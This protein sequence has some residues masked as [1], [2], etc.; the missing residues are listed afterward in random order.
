MIY[1]ICIDENYN[2]EG[3]NISPSEIWKA[4]KDLYPSR[5]I[6]IDSELEEL[7]YET[8]EETQVEI[9]IKYNEC[10]MGY[11]ECV[12]HVSP[13]LVEDGDM[14]DVD[15]YL[16]DVESSVEN[17]SAKKLNGYYGSSDYDIPMHQEDVFRW[18]TDRF[19][20][21]VVDEWL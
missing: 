5:G 11:L 10:D 20:H 9:R 18:V 3:N 8:D 12:F 21:V 4:I 16:W 6:Y 2:I 15:R 19:L 17:A 7:L 13:V 14:G 1:D